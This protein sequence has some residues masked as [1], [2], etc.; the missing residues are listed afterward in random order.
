MKEVDIAFV[1]KS[2]WLIRILLC[3]VIPACL[4]LFF[5]S[6]QAEGLRQAAMTRQ[7]E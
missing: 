6:E 4:N 5:D 7:V 2:S 3:F 1:L